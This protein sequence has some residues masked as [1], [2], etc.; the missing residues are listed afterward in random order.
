MA[1]FSLLG[2]RVGCGGGEHDRRARWG[3][4]LMGLA[5]GSLGGWC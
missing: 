2:G 4:R 3:F 5:R 1:A